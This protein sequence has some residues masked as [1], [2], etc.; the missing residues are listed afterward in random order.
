MERDRDPA[1]W[2]QAWGGLPCTGTLWNPLHRPG[3]QQGLPTPPS[4]SLQGLLDCSRSYFCGSSPFP[5]YPAFP[6]RSLSS[7]LQTVPKVGGHTLGLS[8]SGGQGAGTTQGE[9]AAVD[10][11]G[12]RYLLRLRLR[13]EGPGV[14]R[15]WSIGPWE[16]RSGS[17]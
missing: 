14:W 15:W 6:K 17:D 16:L 2:P 7:A 12:L 11:A 9:G 5:W 13:G 3:M 10:M 1:A 4:Q 8:S